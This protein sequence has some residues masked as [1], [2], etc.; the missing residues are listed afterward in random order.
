M[1]R[2]AR[3]VAATLWMTAHHSATSSLY[4]GHA[5]GSGRA[6][7]A[8]EKARSKATLCPTHGFLL[9]RMISNTARNP[10]LA[11]QGTPCRYSRTAVRPQVAL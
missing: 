3:A 7:A 10:A 9:F 5:S 4:S 6:K 1:G 11:T 8:S 2:S